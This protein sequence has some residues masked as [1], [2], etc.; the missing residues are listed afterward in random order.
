MDLPGYDAWKTTPPEEEL[1]L[2]DGEEPTEEE[3]S[4]MEA[5]EEAGDEWATGDY[6]DPYDVWADNNGETE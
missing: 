4:A 5:E 3:L 1:D 6:L 2:L